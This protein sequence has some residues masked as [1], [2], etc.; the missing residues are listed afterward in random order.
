[1]TATAT[2]PKPAGTLLG[3]AAAPRR[4]L[5]I[6]FLLLAGLTGCSS[7][8]D[9]VLPGS[10]RKREPAAAFV[11]P[12]A[13][14]AVELVIACEAGNWS[15]QLAA[16]P[17][18]GAERIQRVPSVGPDGR[19]T[20]AHFAPWPTDEWLIG[21]RGG[22]RAVLYLP[23]NRSL[24]GWGM[25][26]FAKQ[27]WERLEVG[28]PRP[29]A[30]R[31][32]FDA[33]GNVLASPP[34]S[35]FPHGRLVVGR[36][37][38]P[39]LKEFLRRQKVQTGA[40]GELLELDTD[41]LKVGHVDEILAFVASRGKPGFRVVLP[42][43]GAGLRLLADA[44]AER[45]L[46]YGPGSAETA[47]SVV[48]AGPRYLEAAADLPGKPWR[49][50]RIIRGAGA[51]QVARIR[52]V[53]GR[54]VAIDRVWDLR[55]A[56]AAHVLRSAQDS[57][58]ETMPIWAETPDA[59][60]RYLAVESTRMW[61]DGTGEEFPA[62]MAA[63]ELAHDPALRKTATLC[64]ARLWAKDG[65]I[66]RLLEALNCRAAQVLRLPVLFSSDEHGEYAAAWLPNP[67]NLVPLDDS[68]VLLRPFGPRVD[69]AND[70]SDRFAEVWRAALQRGALRPLFL[71]GW[72]ALH[73]GGGGAHCGTQV[74]R[75]Q[76][77]IGLDE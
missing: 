77:G 42:D 36:S 67:V 71:D 35:M 7:A 37:L 28:A 31:R 23:G 60:S 17:A 61:R 55:G 53:E 29:E 25:P 27:G 48:A 66:P 16:L 64:T 38:H 9:S 69:P 63:G 10:A 70:D 3:S 62:L 40:D 45:A 57:R 20:A 13:T 2:A 5:P 41:W 11:V 32:R 21:A 39:A 8:A 26:F 46:F 43:F 73:R 49:Y 1:M 12:P 34:F 72:D 65:G 56:S 30:D 52:K 74:I 59:T 24:D 19:V 22:R 76:D 44:P 50:L 33:G 51:G 6:L 58:C 18:L 68:V 47:G 54:R 4:L 14:A 75:K 15:E